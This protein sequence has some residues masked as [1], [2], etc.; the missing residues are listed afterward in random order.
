MCNFCKKIYLIKE[1][2]DF[3]WRDPDIVI[4]K[5]QNNK[6]AIWYA[7]EDCYYSGPKLEINYCPICGKELNKNE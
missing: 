5:T 1:C 2:K 4:T 3:G 6:F 7:C